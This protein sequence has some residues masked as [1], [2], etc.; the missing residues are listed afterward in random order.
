MLLDCTLLRRTYQRVVIFF[1]ELRG[2]LDFQLDGADHAAPDGIAQSSLH[3]TDSVCRKAALL[4]KTQYVNAS[5]GT[6]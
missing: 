1:W 2:D 5:T 3:N 4:A 6:Q